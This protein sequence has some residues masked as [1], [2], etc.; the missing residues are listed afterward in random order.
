MSP[1]DEPNMAYMGVGIAVIVGF[2]FGGF[3]LMLWQLESSDPSVF[4]ILFFMMG[5]P[6]IGCGIGLPLILK[7]SGAT[8]MASTGMFRVTRQEEAPSYV[9]E[10]PNSCPNCKASLNS[11]IIEWVGPLTIQCPYCST[12][13]KAEKKR[14]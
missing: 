11:E 6:L 7:S 12:T 13:Q 2:F 14:I 9:F 1:D 3:L 8:T 10:V 4:T 5:F